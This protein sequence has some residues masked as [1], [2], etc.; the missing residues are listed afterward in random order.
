MAD[1][2]MA[3]GL[4]GQPGYLYLRPFDYFDFELYG[5]AENRSTF[6][7]VMVRGLLFGKKYES[8]AD[9]TRGVWGLY[10]SY[11]YLSPQAYR[12]STTAALGTTWQSWLF[13]RGARF[14][15]P[16]WRD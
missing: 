13:Q 7:N 15:E 14:R 10:G 2:S 1:F 4:P 9:D 8:A 6:E 11:D 5:L 16:G 12:L 3:Y